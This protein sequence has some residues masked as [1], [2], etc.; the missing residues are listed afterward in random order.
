M[1]TI[2]EIKKEKSINR[3]A[4]LLFGLIVAQPILDVIS[5]W[6]DMMGIANF[7]PIVRLVV[8]VFF[9]VIGYAVSNSKWAY[10][11]LFGVTST[12]WILH[13]LIVVQA[14]GFDARVVLEDTLVFLRLLT[15]PLFITIIVSLL[16]VG[17][18]KAVSAL[19]KAAFVNL[20]VISIVVLLSHATGTVNYAYEHTM[21]G[22]VGWFSNDN[23]QGI[24]LV[25]VTALSL[26]YAHIRG[27]VW[28][29]AGIL[30]G[31]SALLFVHGSRVAYYSL[32]II[33]IAWLVTF[34]FQRVKGVR[35]YGV[36]VVVIVAAA[37]LSQFSPMYLNR[38]E[39]DENNRRATRQIEEEKKAVAVMA[40]EHSQSESPPSDS[41]QTVKSVYE[42]YALGLVERFGEERVASAF[43]GTTDLRIVRDYRVQKNIFIALSREDS[44]VQER[45]FGH[46]Y[47]ELMSADSNFEPESDYHLLIFLYGYIGASLYWLLTFGSIAFSLIVLMTRRNLLPF[48]IICSVVAGVLLGAGLI[49]G[50]VAIRSNVTIYIAVLVALL[51][52]FSIVSGNKD[53][54]WLDVG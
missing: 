33:A 39:L 30:L 14:S 20:L 26:L 37:G 4:F 54:R 28:L 21:R 29:F 10:W 23:A 32:F 25:S 7:V 2:L 5:Y 42:R 49:A 9:L 1:K 38:V 52:Y 13:C 3:I 34:L 44:S 16:E 19:L 31:G 36:L 15:L 53:G 46:S 41:A 51:I 6:L 43:G 22:T 8:L 35:L 12:F 18:A 17:G 11:L 50:H 45:L 40:P 47:S 24:I 48:A 27:R